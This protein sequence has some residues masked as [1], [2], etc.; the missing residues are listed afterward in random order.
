MLDNGSYDV[1]GAIGL[2]ANK[3]Y[4]K[5]YRELKPLPKPKPRAKAI[6]IIKS[7]KF[8]SQLEKKSAQK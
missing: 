5:F 7:N 3:F 4:T 6:S 1:T 8:A 2:R